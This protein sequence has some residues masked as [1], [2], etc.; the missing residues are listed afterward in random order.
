MKLQ[1]N[2]LIV[3]GALGLC[4]WSMF[5][6]LICLFDGWAGNKIPLSP[7]QMWFMW[8][9]PFITFLFYFSHLFASWRHSIVRWIGGLLQLPLLLTLLMLL[10][11][12][13]P[14]ALLL[15]PTLLGPAIWM[16]YV[17]PHD[18]LNA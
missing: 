5:S 16:R 11:Y 6:L 7:H 18:T 1:R 3:L 4:G 14:I 17:L 8:V 2:I 12:D 10:S 13:A 15:F 9:G